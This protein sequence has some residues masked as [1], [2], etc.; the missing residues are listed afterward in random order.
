MGKASRDKGG[1]GERSLRDHLAF[2][3]FRSGRI[4]LSGAMANFPGDVYA[5]K[6]GTTHLFECKVRAK[7]FESIYKLL[8]ST[9]L[10]EASVA[11]AHE[12]QLIEISYDINHMISPRCD[13]FL[14]SHDRAEKEK[15]TLSKIVRMKKWLGA[16][17]Y[18][19]IKQDRKPFVF[20][21]YL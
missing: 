4:P 3:G 18:L 5:E 13:V 15:R 6:D 12:G 19:A 17:Q 11:F 2:C 16:A 10:T 14:F 1:R 8:A 7:G 21:K 9:A 20:I